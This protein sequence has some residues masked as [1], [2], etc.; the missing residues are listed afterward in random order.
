MLSL[1]TIELFT[2]QKLS[3]YHP[4]HDKGV[5]NRE[6]WVEF[7]PDEVKIQ[8]DLGFQ[9]LQ[10]Q[11]VN[12]EIPHKKPKG[13]ELKAQQKEENRELASERFVC[14]HAF[15]GVKRYGIATHIYRNRIKEFDDHSLFTAAGLWNF[16]LRAA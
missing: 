1:L 2:I 3:V 16:Y 9:G 8:G 11:F 12:V 7:I 5:L 4:D 13:S 14:E 10:N 15:A 6:Q